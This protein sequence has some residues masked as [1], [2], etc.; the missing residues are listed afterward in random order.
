[1]RTYSIIAGCIVLVLLAMPFLI[2]AKTRVT[3]ADRTR[4]HVVFDMDVQPKYKS[5]QE[6]TLFA[7]RRAMRPL[8]PGT[9]ARGRLFTDEHFYQGKVNGEWATEFPM[10]LTM[11]ILEKGHKNYQIFCAPCH[12]L[13]GYGNGIVNVRAERLEE[14]TWTPPTSMHSETVL[15]RPVGHLYNTLTNGIRNMP[16]YAQQIDPQTRWAIIAYVRALQASQRASIE[17]VPQ[18]YRDELNRRQ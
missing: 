11:P 4:F 14:G 2:I 1:M 10:K 6:N 16:A 18:E 9:V 15:E 12:G 3:K 7:D 13:D 8:V 5:Q 17:D